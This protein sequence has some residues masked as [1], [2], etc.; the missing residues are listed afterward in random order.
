MVR[1]SFRFSRIATLAFG[2]SVIL[3]GSPIW[4]GFNPPRTPNRPGNRESAATR[5]L[6]STNTLPETQ[7]QPDL[8]ALVPLSNVGLTTAAYP[9]FYW[10]VPQNTYEQGEFTLY[11]VD[12][13]AEQTPVY[14][15]LFKLGQPGLASLTLP[16][17]ASLSPLE[18]DQ[19]YRW[20]MTLVCD[21]DEPSG[22]KYVE[23]WVTRVSVSPSLKIKLELT[24]A[25][26][27]YNI[28]AKAGLWYDALKALTEMR[29]TQPNH[30]TVQQQW[31]QL[32]KAQAVKLDKVADQT[33][34]P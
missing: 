29:Q 17:T 31:T 28:Y 13:T 2:L 32:L 19:T 33:A 18:V 11:R 22:N 5:G 9:T 30:A 15:S 8:T 27:R 14:Q 3:P 7:N 10:Y 34:R 6:C 21:P 24:K 20:V 16:S 23:G 12:D 26:E 1:S 25:A 4:A